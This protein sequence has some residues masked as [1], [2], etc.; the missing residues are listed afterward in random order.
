MRADILRNSSANFMG[1]ALPALMAIFTLPIIVSHLG[2]ELYGVLSLILAIVGYFALLDIN[3]TAGSV[4]FLAE[5][6]TRHDHDKVRQ[7]TSL[8]LLVYGVIG[9]LGGLVIFFA[10]PWLINHVFTVPAALVPEAMLATRLS[11]LAF[12]IAQMQIYL[13]SIPQSLGRYD[14]SGRFEAV[15]GSL[16]PILT[17]LVVVFGGGLVA[18]VVF[19]L[20]ISVVNVALLWRRVRA[21]LPEFKWALPHLALSRTVM[22]FSGFAYLKRLA[23]I[24]GDQADKVIIGAL[25]GMVAL[26]YFVVPYTL[27]GRV[28]TLT[29]RIGGI[30]FPLASSLAAKGEMDKLREIYLVANRYTLYLNAC[31]CVLFVVLGRTMLEVWMGKDFALQGTYV[32]WLIA[33]ATF[34][35]SLTNLP[36]QINDGLGHPRVSGGFAVVHAVLC[37]GLSYLL[38]GRLGIVGAGL[39]HLINSV[40][41][42]IAFLLYAHGRTVPVSLWLVVSRSIWPPVMYAT[43]IGGFGWWLH[44]ELLT[45]L[46]G[47]IATSLL[48]AMLMVAVG[49]LRILRREERHG[50]GRWML[51]RRPT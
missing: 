3:V 42:G 13:Q 30:L 16:A 32:L 47:G 33:I 45:G 29:N 43:I 41:L 9:L 18:V 27:I 2:K 5:F 10:A 4:K 37:A 28:F 6:H 1:A 48:M 39:A 15:F 36:T 23:A 40:I 51:A 17:A 31:L 22:G 8:G 12:M 7:V 14:I 21:L 24:S 50:L 49:Y 25:L 11:A 35:D 26:T 19:R 44:V 46:L 38:V 20:G 34:F